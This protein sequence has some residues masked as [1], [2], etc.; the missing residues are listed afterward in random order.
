MTAVLSL[1]AAALA[2]P[3]LPAGE[4][5]YDALLVTLAVDEALATTLLP[6]G[7]RLAP[8]MLTPS[9]SHPFIF[10]FGNQSNVRPIRPLPKIFDVSY[11]EF[12][13]AIPYV[14]AC[15]DDGRCRGPFVYSPKLFLD[16]LLPVE[17]GWL[18][19]LNKHVVSRYANGAGF[20]SIGRART[21]M[22]EVDFKQSG[23]FARPSA[24]KNFE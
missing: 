11:F 13:H 9:H 2:P 23:E 18:Y 7:L 20:Q 10:A 24:I 12:I 21:P 1:A 3:W 14:L 8:Q 19:G 5:S 6:P 17:L 16:K 4:G 15:S 22:V